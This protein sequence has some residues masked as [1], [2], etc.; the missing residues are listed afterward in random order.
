MR[1]CEV[2]LAIPNLILA[3]AIMAILGPSLVNLIAV[4]TFSRVGQLL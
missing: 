2:F 3:I 4:L 1:A